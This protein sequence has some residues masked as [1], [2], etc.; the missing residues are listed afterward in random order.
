MKEQITILLFTNRNRTNVCDD[1]S[2]ETGKSRKI[3]GRITN[4]SQIPIENVRFNDKDI[5]Q[6][7]KRLNV[8][9]KQSKPFYIIIDPDED[10]TIGL[11]TTI[12]YEATREMKA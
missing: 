1:I 6:K 2:V 11:D 3:Y 12:S 9:P 10:R 8:G 4:N 7:P 5:L